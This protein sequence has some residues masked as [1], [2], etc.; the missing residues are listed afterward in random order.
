MRDPNAKHVFISVPS[1]YEIPA[2]ANF[3]SYQGAY[4]AANSVTG[5]SSKPYRADFT[6]SLIHI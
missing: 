5:S 1:G 4:Q 2:Q 3:G 6:L